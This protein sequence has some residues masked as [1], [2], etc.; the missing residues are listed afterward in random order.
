MTKETDQ[1]SLSIIVRTNDAK[2]TVCGE[3][4]A[5]LAELSDP[6]R[7]QTVNGTPSPNQEGVPEGCQRQEFILPTE[8]KNRGF[9]RVKGV[10]AP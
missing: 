4:G 2:I 8:G 5:D 6:A 3:A 9:L 10:M 7:V 1:I